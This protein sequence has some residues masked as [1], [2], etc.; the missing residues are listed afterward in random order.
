VTKM[1]KEQI[2]N[3]FLNDEVEAALEMCKKFGF[4][5]LKEDLGKTIN[6]ISDIDKYR[7]YYNK[8]NGRVPGVQI[9]SWG[10]VPDLRQQTAMKHLSEIGASS[11]LDIGC[12]DGT[13]CFFCLKNN[14]VKQIYGIDPWEEG[15]KWANKYSKNNLLNAFF[16]Q[17]LFEDINLDE[18]SFDAVHIGEV[19]EHVIDPV[20]ILRKIRK[21]NIKCVVITI[22][23]K[24]PLVTQ[25]E[26]RKF[27][28][29]EVT[30]HVRLITYQQ[31]EKY[32]N[33][34][35]FK[36]IKSDII[37]IGWVNLIVTII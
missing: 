22:P 26:E 36:I 2:I 7:N 31:L 28:A 4:E 18:I 30:E 12:A 6:H 20:S 11:L 29:C 13:F 1:S 15:I 25:E 37:N 34:T 3:L 24:R 10:N 33:D 9:E 32:C 27:F 35:G 19:L 8:N 16:L 17:G 23:I 5:K 21:H 14:I